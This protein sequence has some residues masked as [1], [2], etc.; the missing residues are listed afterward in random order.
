[1]LVVH[2]RRSSVAPV[3]GSLESA[4]WLGTKLIR[5]HGVES[6]DG[7]ETK[8]SGRKA[9]PFITRLRLQEV[10]RR[11]VKRP[12]IIFNRSRKVDG[13][14]AHSSLH[15]VGYLSAGADDAFSLTWSRGTF[16]GSTIVR[17]APGSMESGTTHGG[18]QGEGGTGRV[19][20]IGT[21]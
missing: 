6:L 2:A 21:V 15:R 13:E 10:R 9:T 12:P 17:V 19:A 16:E 8:R 20:G 5:L 4:S 18:A 14:L 3:H 11:V 1:M 7:D